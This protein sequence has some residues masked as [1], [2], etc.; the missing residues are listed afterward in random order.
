VSREPVFGRDL[1]EVIASSKI[2]LN[3]A[4]DMAGKERGNMRCF[5]AMGCGALLVSDA[6]LYPD[7]MRAGENMLTYTSAEQAIELIERALENWG[8]FSEMAQRGHMM[9]RS[10]Y[11]KERQYS[12]FARLV[13]SI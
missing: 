11:S 12:E 13:E 4:I 9:I 8:Y 1:Y 3:G 2:V 7:G 6:G 10:N 5:E